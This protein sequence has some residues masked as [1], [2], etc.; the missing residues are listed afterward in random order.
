M[1]RLQSAWAIAIIVLVVW[2][3]ILLVVVMLILA[4]RQRR[5]RRKRGDITATTSSNSSSGTITED[6][7][8]ANR[9]TYYAA[10]LGGGK[11]ILDRQRYEREHFSEASTSAGQRSSGTSHLSDAHGPGSLVEASS[12]VYHQPADNIKQQNPTDISARV[13]MLFQ[14]PNSSSNLHTQTNRLQKS[15]IFSSRQQNRSNNFAI[16]ASRPFP[17]SSVAG[18]EVKRIHEQ[19]L[20]NVNVED[21]DIVVR[22]TQQTTADDDRLWYK[23]DVQVIWKSEVECNLCK[24]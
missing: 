19:R 14:A 11:N 9:S 21:E 16:S 13:A 10:G 18:S 5:T 15:P 24:S 7:S 12:G 4:C 17:Q 23:Y 6:N 2:L 22:H 8:P 3:A 20:A 1:F